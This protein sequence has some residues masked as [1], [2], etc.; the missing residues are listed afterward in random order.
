MIMTHTI[1]PEKMS[2]AELRRDARQPAQGAPNTRATPLAAKHSGMEG[3]ASRGGLGG[4]GL[5]GRA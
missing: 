3:R 2:T 4:V 5:E 1:A